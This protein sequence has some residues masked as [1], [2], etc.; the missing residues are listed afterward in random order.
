[1]QFLRVTRN[2]IGYKQYAELWECKECRTEIG[3]EAEKT[4]KK[5]KHPNSYINSQEIKGIIS[6]IIF[7][8]NKDVGKYQTSL[9]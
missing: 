9:S 2:C 7:Q 8:D 6:I 5:T 1:M 3:I 4:V